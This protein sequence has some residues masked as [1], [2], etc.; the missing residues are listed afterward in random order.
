MCT[1]V[2]DKLITWF[3]KNGR[4]FIW[5]ER[6]EPFVVLIA[7]ILLKKTSANVVNQFLPRFLEHY[8]D[9]HAL[10]NATLEELQKVLAPL[11]L[12]AQRGKQ[13]KSLAQ[14]LVQSH[15]GIIPSEQDKLLQL[16]GVGEYTAGAVLSF[17]YRRP[18]A[19]VDTNVARIIIRFYGIERSRCEARRS[20]EVW[21]HAWRLASQYSEGSHRINWAL[22]DLGALICRPERPKCDECPL[23]CDCAFATLHNVSKE[24]QFIM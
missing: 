2:W 16:P 20:P 24:S 21:E 13:L 14:A 10:N 6:R 11:G 12:S 9:V 23:N 1:N 8:S 22:L 7:E 18:E 17:A 5:R 19:I 15:G 3:D 4:S